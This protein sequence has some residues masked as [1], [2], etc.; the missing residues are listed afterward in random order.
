MPSESKGEKKIH[1]VDYVFNLSSESNILLFQKATNQEAANGV[2]EQ[3]AHQQADEI[4]IL[5]QLEID[6][7]DLCDI[8]VQVSKVGENE[9]ADQ[10]EI[11]V[12]KIGENEPANQVE[13]PGYD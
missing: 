10:L 1:V 9:Q 3:P 2:M 6:F 5:T 7:E 12:E 13:I 4:P 11:L 8:E